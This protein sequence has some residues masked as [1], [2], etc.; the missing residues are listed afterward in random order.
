MNANRSR[1]LQRAATVAM[2]LGVTL[3][4]LR[5]VTA[6]TIADELYTS[7]YSR[8]DLSWV[9]A[10]GTR[11]DPHGPLHYLA[12]NPFSQGQNV[13][14]LRAPSIV[15]PSPPWCLCGHGC[16]GVASLVLRR[17]R[18]PRSTRSF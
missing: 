2:A 6:R 8:Q 14:L 3:R 12:R 10:F 7:A 11:V 13:L 16:V 18:L 15:L 17:S 4:L 1:L 9:L 5:A